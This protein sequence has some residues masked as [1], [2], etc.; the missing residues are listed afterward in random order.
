MKQAGL[1]E[2]KALG[3]NGQHRVK[4]EIAPLSR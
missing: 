3:M 4:D 1:Y 2:D